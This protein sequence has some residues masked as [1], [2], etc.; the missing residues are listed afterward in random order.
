M[1]DILTGLEA[2]FDRGENFVLATGGAHLEVVSA[3]TGCGDG[4]VGIR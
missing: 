4:R 2:W 1:R 3:G